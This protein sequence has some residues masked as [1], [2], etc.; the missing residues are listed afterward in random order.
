[1]VRSKK[2]ARIAVLRKFG[3]LS[4]RF[5]VVESPVDNDPFHESGRRDICNVLILPN[6]GRLVRLGKLLIARILAKAK[7]RRPAFP[8]ELRYNGR[9]KECSVPH[10]PMAVISRG[11]RGGWSGW[12]STEASQLLLAVFSRDSSPCMVNAG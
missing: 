6:E 8:G 5:G 10:R 2:P 4:S 11:G 12:Q 9:R 1:M 7:H 3:I